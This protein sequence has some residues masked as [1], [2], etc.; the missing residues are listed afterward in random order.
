MPTAVVRALLRLTVAACPAMVTNTSFRLSI[1]FGLLGAF[2][3]AWTN[4]LGTVCPLPSW[5]A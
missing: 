4:F 1:A 3:G 2:S 5:V